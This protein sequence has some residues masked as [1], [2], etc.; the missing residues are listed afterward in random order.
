[1]NQS[2]GIQEEIAKADAILKGERW[3][4]DQTYSEKLYGPLGLTTPMQRATATTAIVA[5]GL[6]ITE[7]SAMFQRG[8]IRPFK[9]L[10]MDNPDGTWVHPFLVLPLVFFLAGGLT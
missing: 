1:M 10:D 3:W 7:P 8:K 5:S 4:G 2:P 6:F 9:L